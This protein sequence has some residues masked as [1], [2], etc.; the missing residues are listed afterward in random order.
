MTNHTDNSWFIPHAHS[1][2]WGSCVAPVAYLAITVHKDGAEIRP[3]CDRHI[4]NFR[5]GGN[6][7]ADAVVSI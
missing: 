6:L 5:A 2:D 3:M 7:P 1:C 4:A